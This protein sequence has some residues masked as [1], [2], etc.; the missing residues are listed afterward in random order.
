MLPCE[1][2]V[3]E[4]AGAR[5]FTFFPRAEARRMPIP[6]VW[7]APTFLDNSPGPENVP[8]F[9]RWLERGI[10]VVGIEVD[11][12]FG[13]PAGR[14]VFTAF[15]RHLTEERDFARKA[16]LHPQSRGGLMLYNWAVE[17]PESV[18]A[19]VGIYTVCDIRSYPGIVTAAPAYGM[20]ADELEATLT[21]HNPIDRLAPLAAQNV[22]ILH[23]HGDSD[24]LVPLETNSAEFAL[25]YRA[26]GGSM[27]V[28]VVPGKGHE[29]IPEYFER[30]DLM[31][32]G[33]REAKRR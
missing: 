29:A 5:A 19:S 6:W 21:E 1:T 20:T 3:F 28:I 23:I 17:H 30:E 11:E 15:Y 18:A 14:A 10:A 27:E 31:D 32:F 4:V 25:R 13:N 7:Y 33:E 2:D 9:R 24:T 26:L 22:P 16:V 8:M 12:S